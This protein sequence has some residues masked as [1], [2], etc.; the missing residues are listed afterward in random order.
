MKV[1]YQVTTGSK[2][3]IIGTVYGSPSQNSFKIKSFL[4]NLTFTSRYFQSQ[5][6]DDTATR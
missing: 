6:L 3:C 5:L 1:L 2:K 4:S